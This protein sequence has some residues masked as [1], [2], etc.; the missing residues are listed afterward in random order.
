MY[1]VDQALDITLATV[2]LLEEQ[3]LLEC[4]HQ[5]MI[6]IIFQDNESTIRMAMEGHGD[7]KR[8]KMI[9][10]RF[11]FITEKIAN[12]EVRLQYLPSELLRADVF[13]KHL[14]GPAFQSM[15]D[16][17]MGPLVNNTPTLT[18]NQLLIMFQ[19]IGTSGC[20]SR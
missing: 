11:Y 17:I 19:T 4:D 16:K 13:T 10:P 9:N 7:F 14:H 2:Y 20:N 15:M 1:S 5:G 6:P 18:K 3:Q 8:T 12:N